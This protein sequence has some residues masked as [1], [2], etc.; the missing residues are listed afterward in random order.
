MANYGFHKNRH[1]VT[2][3]YQLTSIGRGR[4]I[5]GVRAEDNMRNTMLTLGLAA[6]GTMAMSGALLAQQQQQD[7]SQHLNE[8]QREALNTQSPRVKTHKKH[9][10]KN[11][12]YTVTS[13]KTT[14][15]ATVPNGK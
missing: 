5:A 4:G 11:N 14:I 1:G 8:F 12:G 6:L 3:L 2:R 7:K 13:N 10:N 9:T 15:V